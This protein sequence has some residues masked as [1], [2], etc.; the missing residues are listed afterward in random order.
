MLELIYHSGVFGPIHFEYSGPTVRV[1]SSEDNDLVLRHPS[2]EFYH[3]LLV[4]RGEKVL[5]LPP[6]AVLSGEADLWQAPGPEFGA[7]D[8]I[9]VGD[10]RLTLAHSARSVAIPEVR[11]GQA[12]APAPATY[13]AGEPSEQPSP[14][15]YFCPR[16]QV[17]VP[18]TKVN[19]V[20]LVGHAKRYLCPKCST[21]LY[22]EERPPPPAPTRKKRR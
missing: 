13:P 8:E 3:C 5:C 16:C 10:L 18:E 12:S 22:S 4:F 2:V 17:V 7:G 14:P 9:Q 11:G 1:G 20:G 15:G 6:D 19:R 21:L